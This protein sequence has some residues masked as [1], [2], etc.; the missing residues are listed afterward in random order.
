MEEYVTTSPAVW[1]FVIPVMPEMLVV[2][3]EP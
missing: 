1:R 2:E 3:V